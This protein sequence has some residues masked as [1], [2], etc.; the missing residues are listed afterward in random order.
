MEALQSTATKALLIYSADDPIVKKKQHFD[1]LARALA[2]RENVS[3]L[4]VEGKAHN[5]NYTADAVSYLG[6]FFA[7]R[8]EKQR[9]G[10]LASK[11]QREAFLAQYDWD[12][13]TAQDGAVWQ[14]VLAHLENK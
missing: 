11:A 5:P 13:M 10:E 8:A 1:V 12:R 4:L 2:G 7:A 6:S 3:L 14:A 9:A